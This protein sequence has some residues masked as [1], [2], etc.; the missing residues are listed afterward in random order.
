M[1]QT[2]VNLL[3]EM[4]QKHEREVRSLRLHVG[5]KCEDLLVTDI[6]HAH[7]H[8]D[9]HDGIQEFTS[10][11]SSLYPYEFRW[12]TEVQVDVLLEDL[13]LDLSVLFKN[14]RIIITADHEDL[15]DPVTDQ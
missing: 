2:S 7:H 4:C 6:V 5:G 13:R 1:S 8:V 14:E 12:I 11:C 10:L 15:S 3:G 9:S